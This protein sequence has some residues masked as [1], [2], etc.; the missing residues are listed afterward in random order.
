MNNE[1][2][3]DLIESLTQEGILQ[4]PSVIRAMRLVPREKFLPEGSKAYGAVDSP[5]PIG[6]GQTVSAPHSK[7]ER[8][9]GETWFQ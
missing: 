8:L 2:W 3:N 7:L 6:W 5:L 9:L 4:S 1:S